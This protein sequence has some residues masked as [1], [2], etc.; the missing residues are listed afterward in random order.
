MLVDPLLHMRGGVERVVSRVRYNKYRHTFWR[1]MFI[2]YLG[3]YR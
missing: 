1:Y 3:V 2:G